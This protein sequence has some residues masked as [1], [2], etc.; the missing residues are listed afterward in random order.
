MPVISAGA[1]QALIW[2]G[3][4]HP[5]CQTW[6][7]DCRETYFW[8]GLG[9]NPQFGPHPLQPRGLLGQG[10]S[11]HSPRACLGLLWPACWQDEGQRAFGPVRPGTEG[12][13]SCWWA[14]GH[15]GPGMEG[16]WSCHHLQHKP[17]PSWGQRQHLLHGAH[18]TGVGR[19]AGEKGAEVRH[20]ME[21][22]KKRAGE[23]G[24]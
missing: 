10:L 2:N 8:L 22:R 5:K 11:G 19:R 3:C 16:F 12:F 6:P 14:F 1:T 18:P 17:R 13:W 23:K 7:W 20:E 15:V 9:Q 24:K 4:S 21:R